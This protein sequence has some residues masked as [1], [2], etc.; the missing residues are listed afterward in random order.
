M[1]VK[2]LES[3]IVAFKSSLDNQLKYLDV[4][5]SMLDHD[6]VYI[7]PDIDVNKAFLDADGDFDVF[8]N[9][10]E[11]KIQGKPENHRLFRASDFRTDYREALLADRKIISRL[12]DRWNRNDF[13]PKFERFKQ[14]IPE[15][16][17]PEINNPSGQNKPRVVIFS[18]AIDTLKSI[19]RALK[20]AGHRPL[21]ITAENREEM[22]R[23]ISENFDANLAPDK[24]RDDYDAIVTTE[25]L[26]EGVNLHRA[27]VILNYDA[28]W[29]ATRLMQ[30]IGRAN[31]IGS[32]E[33]FV[34]VYNFFPS[35][36]GNKEIRLVEKAYAKL[37]SFHEMF[38]EDS[39]VFSE[40][41]EVRENDL[42]HAVDGDES[43]FGIYIRELKDFASEHPERFAYIKS[44]ALDSLG[45]YY[46]TEG[47][48]D[49]LYI[50]TDQTEGLVSVLSADGSAPKASIISPLLTMQYLHCST[51]A[52]FT[53]HEIDKDCDDYKDAL[54]AYQNHVTHRLGGRDSNERIKDT[55]EYVR[56]LRGRQDITDKT[57]RLLAQVNSL[58]RNKNN[59]VIKT[60]LKQKQRDAS[61]QLSLFGADFEINSWLQTTF[62]HI[63]AQ[64][65]E[66]RGQSNVAIAIIK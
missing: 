29:N 57:K 66:R 22:A 3:S 45:G 1:L 48:S 6:A 4:M 47:C 54:R 26:A 21:A 27:N 10:M 55:Q 32:V 58:V 25:V 7:C 46:P 49:S 65:Q 51:E 52:H 33:D 11:R 15:L 50:F 56:E 13:D 61:G 40:R 16:F 23:R 36:E 59:F 35:D 12:L 24:R 30:R 37:Q 62:T 63:A 53:S 60:L 64:A 28:P 9:T 43:P 18:E 20:N 38:G 31:R 5:I 14:A 19:E 34:H 17:N 8:Q 42:S 41:E 2:R 44:L 39:K